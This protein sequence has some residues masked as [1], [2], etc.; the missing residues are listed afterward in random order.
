MNIVSSLSLLVQLGSLP[1]LKAVSLFTHLCSSNTTD[2]GAGAAFFSVDGVPMGT[3]VK[4]LVTHF[5]VFNFHCRGV[6]SVCLL[7]VE[8]VRL[9]PFCSLRSP[10]LAI[11]WCLL[12]WKYLLV[13]G[14]FL[15]VSTFSLLLSVAFVYS[16]RRF[17][18]CKVAFLIKEGGKKVKLGQC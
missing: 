15:Y 13:W 6:V 17:P 5:F 9:P 11:M 1:A 14:L 7:F 16:I 12:F 2:P 4:S 18:H 10:L 8:C 3:L